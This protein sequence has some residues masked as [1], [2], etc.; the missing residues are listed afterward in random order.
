MEGEE[1]KEMR[2][3]ALGWKK[4][5]EKATSLRGHLFWIWT[6]SLTRS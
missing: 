2:K 3:N 6:T 5:I 1:G 4:K